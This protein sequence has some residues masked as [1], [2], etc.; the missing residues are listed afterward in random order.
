MFG[1]LKSCAG[2]LLL[3]LVLVL[4]AAWVTVAW[5]GE[6]PDPLGRWVGGD[7]GVSVPEPTAE[8]AEETLERFERLRGQE[9]PERLSLGRAEISSVVRYA[10]PGVLPPGVV[11]PAVEMEDRKIL[12]AAR[13][14]TGA[15]PDLPSLEEV[16]GFLPDTVDIR[17]R[18]S[19][20][21]FDETQA[22][23][24]V[25]RI[26]A[27]RIPLP[28]RFTPEVLAAL[29]REDRQGLPPDAL[30]IPLPSGIESVYV[31]RDSLVLVADR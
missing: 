9:G 7:R 2:R 28:D 21:P 24:H 13:V 20:L 5:D 16:V 22:A 30:L 23:L 27:M 3:L 11:D 6:L 18:G 10:L 26:V 14:A 15:F 12:L 17:M 8:L 29:G 1:C 4:G 19:L 25:D 31:L